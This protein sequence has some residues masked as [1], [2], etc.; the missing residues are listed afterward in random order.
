MKRRHDP[1]DPRS[2]YATGM[3]SGLAILDSGTPRRSTVMRPGAGQPA[4]PANS[5]VTRRRSALPHPSS[6]ASKLESTPP[7]QNRAWV[8]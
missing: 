3:F 7:P 2:N 1:G 5:R 8:P 4:Q 6:Q